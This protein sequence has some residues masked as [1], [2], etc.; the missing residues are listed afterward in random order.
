M[1]GT[2]Q[3][4]VALVLLMAASASGTWP[5]GPAV[6]PDVRRQVASGRSRVLVDL[7]VEPPQTPESIAAA[8][9]RVLGALPSG[10]ATLARRYTSVPLLA[11]EVDAD[12]LRALERLGDAVVRV[13]LDALRR[14][15]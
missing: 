12:G 13:R 11:L 14:P 9:E 7:R 8:Q 2:L 10:H 1:R 6:D 5:P 4:A 15:Q 3:L